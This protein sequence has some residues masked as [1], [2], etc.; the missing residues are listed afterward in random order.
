[1]SSTHDPSG[2]LKYDPSH[3][4]TVGQLNRL[5]IHSPPGQTNDPFVHVV[6]VGTVPYKIRA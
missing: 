5:G 4:S 1:M 3:V 2:H 6:C